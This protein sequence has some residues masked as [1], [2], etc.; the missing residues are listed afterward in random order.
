MSH[1]AQKKPVGNSVVSV[2]FKKER[3]RREKEKK[4]Q[5]E[6]EALKKILECA[7]TLKW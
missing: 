2:D 5:E 1:D 7:K 3:E 4:E 6:A